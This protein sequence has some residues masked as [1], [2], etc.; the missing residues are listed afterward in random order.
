M[1]EKLRKFLEPYIGPGALP[2]DRVLPEDVDM[3]IHFA[4]DDYTK[5]E[6]MD[7]GT[8][9]PEAPFWDFLK[10][11]HPMTPEEIEA[12]QKEIDSEPD[13]ED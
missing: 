12:L 8:A 13:D 6:I 4:V 9:H 11:I 5:Q 3:L 1:E 10:L 2:K 7:Y